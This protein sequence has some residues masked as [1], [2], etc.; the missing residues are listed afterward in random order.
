MTTQTI[1]FLWRGAVREID[2]APAT[3]TV[4]QH[5]RETELCTGT[6]EGC[7]EGDCGAC[8][9]VVG[10]LDE[11]G[12]LA[13]KAVNACIQFLP[14]LDSRAL[15]TVEDLRGADGALHPVQQAL[16]DCHGSQCGFCTPGFVMSLWAL[17][18]AHPNDAGPPSRDEI[19]TAISG[20][21]C[22]CTGYRPIVDAAERMFDYPQPSFDRAA[23]EASLAQLRRTQTFEYRA[24]DASDASVYRAPVTRAEFARLRAANPNARL[25]AGSTDIGLWVTK[26]FRDL[27]DILFIGNV[28]ELKRIERDAQHL[29]IGAAASLEDAYAAL[30]ADYP[31]LAELWTRFASRPIRNAGTIGGNVANGS[32]IGDSMPALIALNAELVLQHGDKTRTVPLD[33]FYLAYQKTAL[34]AGEFVAAIRVPRP[35]ADLRFRTYKV[36]KRY[37]QDISAVCAAFAIRLDG[38]HRVTDARIAFGGMAAT[39]KRAS[40]AEAALTGCDWTEASVRAAMAALDSDFQ[41]LTDMRASSAYRAK[42]ARNVLLRFYLETRAD[43]PLALAEVNAFAYGAHASVSEEQP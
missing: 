38:A 9:V 33:A 18:H 24:T 26:Q 34:T 5:L 14:T 3:R 17:Y 29:T 39:P 1:R 30:T 10:E 13:L 4:L 11:A 16:V 37:D 7:A 32:P 20:N 22:R 40:N 36:S 19:A 6:K 25:L 35:S 27:G 41:P 8:T 31:E 43:A 28:D 12:K 42:V 2:D 15:F 23:I 21:L